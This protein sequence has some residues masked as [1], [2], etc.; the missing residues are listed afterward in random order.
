MSGAARKRD[1]GTN[2][3]KATEGLELQPFKFPENR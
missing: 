3:L 2:H 1:K